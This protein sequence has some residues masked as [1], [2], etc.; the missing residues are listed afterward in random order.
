MITIEYVDV[1]I[2]CCYYVDIDKHAILVF[3]C[4]LANLD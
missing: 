3:E 2:Q 1:Y 4:E